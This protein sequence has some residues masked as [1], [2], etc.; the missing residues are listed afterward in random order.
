[1]HLT[2]QQTVD[3]LFSPMKPLISDQSASEMREKKTPDTR[4]F[5]AL[6]LER[7]KY[8]FRT[9]S[10]SRFR[11]VLIWMDSKISRQQSH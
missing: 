3:E 8:N 9:I 11:I 1:V 7:F 2:A 4:A 10:N 5:P 6:G